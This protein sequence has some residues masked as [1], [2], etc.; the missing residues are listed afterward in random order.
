M[1]ADKLIQY[2]TVKDVYEPKGDG[3]KLGGS[4]EFGKVNA[5]ISY[6]IHTSQL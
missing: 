6:V 4:A 3:G 1:N 2:P 5:H